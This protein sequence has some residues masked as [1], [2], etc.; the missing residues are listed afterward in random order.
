MQ[1]EAAMEM[2]V[3]GIMCFIMLVEKKAEVVGGRLCVRSG[4]SHRINEMHCKPQK[5][6]KKNF[7][8]QSC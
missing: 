5:F 6:I 2:C 1:C 3:S 8:F 7:E 4:Y